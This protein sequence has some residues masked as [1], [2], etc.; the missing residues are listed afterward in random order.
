M[1]RWPEEKNWGRHYEKHLRDAML[2]K[3]PAIAMFNHSYD[4]FSGDYLVQK[5]S[6]IDHRLYFYHGSPRPLNEKGKGNLMGND[7]ILRKLKYA[8][9]NFV[10]ADIRDLE[11]EQIA[12]SLLGQKVKLIVTHSGKMGNELLDV[13]RK[14]NIPLIVIFHATDILCEAMENRNIK[15]IDQLFSQAALL[16]GTSKEICCR[17]EDAGCPK[18]KI[19]YLPNFLDPELLN[20]HCRGSNGNMFITVGRHS[21]T[22]A[23]YLVILSFKEVIRKLPDAKLMIVGLEMEADVT[24]VC[25]VMIKALGLKDSV[26]F[27]HNSSYSEVV[28]AMSRADVFVQHFVTEMIHGEREGTP[29]A[30]LMAMA[31]GLP[32]V[33]SRNG[34]IGELITDGETGLLTDEFDYMKMAEKMV[35]MAQDETLRLTVIENA[36]KVIKNERMVGSGIEV[37]SQMVDACVNPTK[38]RQSAKLN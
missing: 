6:P 4:R 34:G 10:N 35:Q 37:F 31:M 36:H 22:R 23:P 29:L 21:P 18:D 17:L 1:L 3:R 9:L 8:L 27:I 25:R 11:D 38:A 15:E 30:V 14:T 12:K 16:V 20:M 24:E 19:G 2:E 7:E 13:A 26:S 5:F 33:A 32:V 28:K